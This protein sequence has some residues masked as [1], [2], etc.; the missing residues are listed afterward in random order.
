MDFLSPRCYFSSESTIIPAEVRIPLTDQFR[1]LLSRSLLGLSLA[2]LVSRIIAFQTMT[3]WAQLPYDP[4]HPTPVDDRAIT[5]HTTPIL[6]W[7]LNHGYVFFLFFFA[8][9]AFS[10]ILESR[11]RAPRPGGPANLS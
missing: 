9:F 3:Y 7:C 4:A 11:P 5:Y 1:Q 2:L 8:A 6:G 10:A